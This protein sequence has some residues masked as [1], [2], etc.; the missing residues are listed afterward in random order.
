MR[1]LSALGVGFL[2]GIVFAIAFVWL[3]GWL[4]RRAHPEAIMVSVGL[5]RMLIAFVL[6]FGVGFV[7]M[8]RRKK[9]R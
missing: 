4:V 5:L 7:W 1:L 6:G 9:G 8:M 3:G 2:M